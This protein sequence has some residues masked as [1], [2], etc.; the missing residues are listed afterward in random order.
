MRRV[1][2]V[3]LLLTALV[4]FAAVR[5]TRVY[6]STGAAPPVPAAGT[7]PDAGV[8]LASASG[9]RVLAYTDAGT[10]WGGVLQAYYWDP[11]VGPASSSWARAPACFD[12]VL[13]AD[14]GTPRAQ[15]CADLEPLAAYGRL[16]Y[17][18]AGVVSVDGG[19]VAGLRVRVECWRFGGF[20]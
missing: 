15:V 7:E 19:A 17:V 2:R 1:L 20:Q 14:A 8:D 16:A 11:V 3:L 4:V 6:D 9:C 12:C 18:A 5:Q 10:I 13:Q